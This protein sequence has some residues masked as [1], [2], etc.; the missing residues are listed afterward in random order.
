[1]SMSKRVVRATAGV[2]QAL[3]DAISPE[4]RKRRDAAERAADRDDMTGL[5]NRRALDRALPAAEKDPR[6]AVVLFDGDH[7]GRVNKL[8]GHDVGD[9]AI[10]DMAFAIQSEADTVGWGN[11]AFRAGGD[12]FV[13][14]L[15]WNLSGLFRDRVENTF[16]R[17]IRPL[18]ELGITGVIGN[19][20]READGQLAERKRHRKGRH[21][22]TIRASA[23]QAQ[24]RPEREGHGVPGPAGAVGREVPEGAERQEDRRGRQRHEGD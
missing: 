24:D 17:F 2:R 21:A 22:G 7:F 15:P 14:L 5:A 23:G 1:M 8:L 3:A 13:V 10:Q 12:E 6:M 18:D 9:R 19:T 4:G 20:L 16:S 11:R